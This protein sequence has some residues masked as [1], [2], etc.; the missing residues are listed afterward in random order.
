LIGIGVLFLAINLLPGVQATWPI[1]SHL[2]R[3][4][5][6]LPPFI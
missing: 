3:P 2:L 1:L 4:L 6:F 5:F